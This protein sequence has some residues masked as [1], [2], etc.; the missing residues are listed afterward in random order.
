CRPQ[1][2]SN[3][4]R[5]FPSSLV[6]RITS[7][8]LNV[9]VEATAHPSLKGTGPSPYMT[10]G[11]PKVSLGRDSA[12]VLAPD[13]SPGKRVVKPARRFWHPWGLYRLRRNSDPRCQPRTSVRG[14]GLLSARKC[15]D[16]ETE[17][18]S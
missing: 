18:F 9:S 3:L 5:T 2:T 14:S 13:F 16:T 10:Q 6:S 4:R 15:P 1:F 7:C 8:L 12:L 17:G 11:H